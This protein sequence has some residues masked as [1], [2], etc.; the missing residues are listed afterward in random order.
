[1]LRGKTGHAV[2][3]LDRAIDHAGGDRRVT[4]GI[5]QDEAAGDAIGNVWIEDQRPRS[6]DMRHADGIYFQ[7]FGLLF[8]ER[9]DVDAVLD[10]GELGPA[11]MRRVLDAIALAGL[12]R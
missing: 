10:A 11:L 6:F 4:R 2:S 8:F 1:E 12:R 3:G 9:I 5:D 7:R